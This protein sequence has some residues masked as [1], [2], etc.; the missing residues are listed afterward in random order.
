MDT[1]TV[2]RKM[3]RMD[4]ETAQKPMGE[5]DQFEVGMEKIPMKELYGLHASIMKEVQSRSHAD[6]T[7][8]EVGRGVAKMLQIAC[9]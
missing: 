1:F 3:V 4:Q 8:L 9:E 2:K 6:A 5:I 7:N